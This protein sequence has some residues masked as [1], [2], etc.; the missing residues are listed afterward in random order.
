MARH[1]NKEEAGVGEDSFL[2]TTANLVGILIILVVVIGAKTKVDAEEYGREL[3]KQQAEPES[4][5]EPKREAGALV[6]QLQKQKLNLVQY[7][8]ENAFRQKERDLLLQKVA[9]AR[10]LVSEDLAETDET[11]QRAIEETIRKSQLESALKDVD[12]QLGAAEAAAERPKI[13][14]EHLPTPMAKT[15]FTR[16][17]HIQLRNG[18]VTVIPWDRLV[19]MLKQH[20]P[21]AVNR[22]A[23]RSNIED[24]L[25]PLGGFLMHYRMNAVAGGFELDRFELEL[26]PSAVTE[27]IDETLQPTGRLRLEL[28]S[29][30]PAETVITVWVYPESFDAFRTLKAKLFDEGF[31]S[32]A[33]PLPDDVRIGASPQGTRS[34]AQ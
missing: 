10:E 16:E 11:K 22:N 2:D 28:A 18:Q 21:L 20:L 1:R 33:R 6:E 26:T 17:M 32:A 25:G 19:G 4:L 34:S 27:T 29:R 8:R 9:Y 30:N 31:L 3:A 15:V 5:K 24:T 23:S 7:D 13:I 14:L 12:Q